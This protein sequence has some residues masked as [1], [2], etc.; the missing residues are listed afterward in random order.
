MMEI[1]SN[2]LLFLKNKSI[3]I[4]KEAQVKKSLNVENR[5]FTSKCI[6]RPQTKIVVHSLGK[7][8]KDL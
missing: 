8:R 6:Y 5:C 4:E 2:G 3:L 1:L 7:I